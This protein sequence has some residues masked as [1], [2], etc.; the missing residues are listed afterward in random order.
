M[1]YTDIAFDVWTD[2][3]DRFSQSNAPRIF[4]LQRAISSLTQGQTTVANYFS[5][6]KAY[7]DELSFYSTIPVCTCSAAKEFSS[8]QQQERLMQ[9][10]MGLNETYS[11]VCG[12]LLLMDPLPNINKA[13]SLIL[14]EEKQREVSVPHTSHTD[15]AA[16]IARNSSRFHGALLEHSDS[17]TSSKDTRGRRRP[18]PTCD[19]CGFVGHTKD[20]CYALHSYP[21]GHRLFNSSPQV[22]APHVATPRSTTLTN[23]SVSSAAPTF[24]PDQYR[25]LLSLLNKGTPQPEAHLAGNHSCCSTSSPS[26]SWVIDTGAT[27]HMAHSFSSL[28]SFTAPTHPSS[29]NLPNGNLANVTHVGKRDV[30]E[31]IISMVAWYY[32]AKHA[33]DI[34]TADQCMSVDEDIN[35]DNIEGGMEASSK[36]TKALP[37]SS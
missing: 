37:F 3:D 7:W 16:L 29:V 8:Y 12:Q 36:Q 22:P 6:L 25:Q 14:Q 32:I 18:R 5:Q 28:H 31:G 26:Q 4:Q 10:L 15:A 24:T 19:H 21:P 33:E 27:N 1:I 35:L 2:L 30:E 23:E 11:T 20:K 34:D 13:Y 9:F 17:H